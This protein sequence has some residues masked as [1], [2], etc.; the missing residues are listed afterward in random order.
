VRL[1]STLAASVSVALA[2]SALFPHKK[3][4][5]G[6]SITLPASHIYAEQT[7]M[8]KELDGKILSL[9]SEMKVSQNNLK[10]L[11]TSMQSKQPDSQITRANQ[12]I[13]NLKV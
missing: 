11:Q 13:V 6:L 9:E 4:I 7:E 3:A 8:I 1:L 2:V 12:G 10:M 5:E